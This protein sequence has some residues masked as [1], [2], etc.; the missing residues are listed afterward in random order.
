MT[1]DEIA[2]FLDLDLE[3]GFTSEDVK[4]AYENRTERARQ[5]LANAGSKPDRLMA[6]GRLSRL[7][8]RSGEIA[9]FVSRAKAYEDYSKF[10]ERADAFIRDKKYSAA[11]VIFAKIQTISRE[12]LTEEICD[13]ID[14]IEAEIA[15]GLGSGSHA[16]EEIPV[17]TPVG[18]PVEQV[19]PKPPAAMAPKTAIVELPVP[20]SPAKPE[21]KPEP[22]VEKAPPPPLP[23]PPQPKPVIA[24]KAPDPVAEKAERVKAFLSKAEEALRE[25]EDAKAI[26]FLDQAEG[27]AESIPLQDDILSR[28]GGIRAIL[29]RRARE[30]AVISRHKDAMAG[31]ERLMTRRDYVQAAA[32]LKDSVREPPEGEVRQIWIKCC[33]KQALET[34][35]KVSAAILSAARALLNAGKKDE[36]K[37]ALSAASELIQLLPGAKG[38]AEECAK[39]GAIIN[40]N[41]PES[42]VPCD[43]FT[44]E[45][46]HGDMLKRRLHVVSRQAVTFGRSNSFS[47]V[48]V[49]V[50]ATSGDAQKVNMLISKR[51]FTIERD[52]NY[53]IL[54]DGAKQDNGTFEASKNGVYLDEKRITLRDKIKGGELLHIATSKLTR[55]T[56]QWSL[57]VIRQGESGFKTPSA[58]NTLLDLCGRTEVDGVFLSRRDDTTEDVLVLWGAVPLRL[59]DDSM[60]EI[61]LVKDDAGV[62]IWDGKAFYD[63]TAF[64]GNPHVMSVG[65]LSHI[66]G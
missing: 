7:A 47:D 45:Y 17:E 48:I 60:T 30:A 14:I 33:K 50:M 57:K 29:D 10:K 63:I 24:E 37:Q 59:V 2:T 53:A 42:I 52:E 41:V 46:R 5:D 21:P 4:K 13:E 65:K 40:L 8:K 49:R 64:K 6:N 35:E 66:G 58:V 38:L 28:I 15:G 3:K 22:V 55:D 19:I 23:P 27:L 43:R 39:L 20:V 1:R 12:L 54:A 36:A 32:T 9:D 18:K 34:G 25:G 44:I 56:A 26:G 16:A 61:W 51:H 31:V 62:L 11:K